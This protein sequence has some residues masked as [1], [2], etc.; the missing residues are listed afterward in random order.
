MS[1][2][3]GDY[4]SYKTKE[5]EIDEDEDEDEDEDD[6]EIFGS[7]KRKRTGVGSKA[8]VSKNPKA[9]A[10]AAARGGAAAVGG[11]TDD[12]HDEVGAEPTGRRVGT[13][14]TR[15]AA[16]AQLDTIALSDESGEDDGGEAAKGGAR[17]AL[18]EMRAAMKAQIAKHQQLAQEETVDDDDDSDDDGGGG[19]RSAET[20]PGE[21]QHEIPTE[22]DPSRKKVLLKLQAPGGH[23]V[24]MKAFLDAPFQ[25]LFDQYCL[26]RGLDPVSVHFMLVRSIQCK[27]V[28]RTNC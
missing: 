27:A 7:K 25:T 6:E 5:L 11:D 21:M 13:R 12:D 28:V 24:K 19:G 4:F 18:E 22:P 17:A 10:A 9:A 16:G 15:G 26:N 23:E 3:E 2:D 1:D 8:A 20:G 14:R